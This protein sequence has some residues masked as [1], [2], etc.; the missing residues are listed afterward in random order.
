MVFGRNAKAIVFEPYPDTGGVLDAWL[1][2]DFVGVDEDAHPVTDERA[3][4]ILRAVE[5]SRGRFEQRREDDS[6]EIARRDL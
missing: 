2:G 3:G 1:L 5:Q 4:Q 6:H